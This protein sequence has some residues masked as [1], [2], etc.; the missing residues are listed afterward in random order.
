MNASNISKLHAASFDELYTLVNEFVPHSRSFVNSVSDKSTLAIELINRI[1]AVNTANG[2][3]E[4][5]WQV[6]DRLAQLKA[7]KRASR[8]ERRDAGLS[9]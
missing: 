7:T 3:G 5:E 9:R 4:E 8:K 1:S 6:M 2:D